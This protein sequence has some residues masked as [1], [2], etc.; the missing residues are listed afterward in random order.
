MPDLVIVG[1]GPAGLAAAIRASELGLESLV[2]DESSTA[3]GQYYRQKPPSFGARRNHRDRQQERGAELIA[4]AHRGA[5]FRLGASV[6]AID[7]ARVWLDEQG[8][9]D[10][11]SAPCI[12]LATGAHDRPTPFPGWTLPGVLTAGGAQ[13]LV[14]GQALKPGSLAVVAGSGPFLLTVAA[15]LVAAGVTVREVVE[16]A[17]IRES[18]P[19]VPR[20]LAHPARYLELGRYL[21][22][23]VHHGVKL[24]RGYLIAS[25][26]G[27]ERL[28]R[29]HLEPARPGPARFRSIDVDLLCVGYGFSASTELARLAGCELSWDSGLDQTVPRCDEWQAT[30]VPGLFVAG[31]ACGL[32]GATVAELQG[33]VAAIGVA[34]HL[35]RL[36]CSDASRLAAPLHHRL[37]RARGFVGL[38][39]RAFPARHRISEMATDE[40][41]VCRCQN[42]P[43]GTIRDA[44]QAGARDLNEVKTSTRCGMGWCQGRICGAAL[45]ALL[46]GR[47][48]PAF[49]LITSFTARPPLRPLPV[50]TLAQAAAK[51]LSG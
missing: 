47:V 40:T 25:A 46:R 16:A 26:E 22:P 51:A 33:H 13:A 11:V 21:A 10:A 18:L 49:D 7:T 48:D 28:E 19:L 39:T 24:T 17:T 27:S 30:S 42:V 31:E 29:V 3:G 38:L 1:A 34:R 9:T 2:V 5:A 32:G 20:T 44:V 6:W 41:I 45:P 14:K 8:S 4:R 12:L 43:W 15:H 36:S 23:L 35:G 37:E 50:S